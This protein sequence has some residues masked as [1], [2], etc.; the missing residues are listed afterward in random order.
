MHYV[1]VHGGDR[2][3]LTTQLDFIWWELQ[4]YGYGYSNLTAATN[5][6]DATI[7]FEVHYEICGKCNQSAR[8]ANAKAVL[9]A[10]GGGG[11]TGA[12]CYSGTLGK[13]IPENTCLQSKF[14][15]LWYQC[16]NGSWVDRWSDPDACNGVYP[17]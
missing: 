17:L 15:M 4:N 3:S 9:A 13:E 5:V 10:Y 2:W 12:G 8:I 7:A 11:T 14:D 1:S 16:S 6:S